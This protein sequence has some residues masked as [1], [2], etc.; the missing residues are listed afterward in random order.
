MEC[1]LSWLMAR[2]GLQFSAADASCR[3]LWAF[4]TAQ[5]CDQRARLTALL[6]TLGSA[7]A[8]ARILASWNGKPKLSNSLA[9][10]MLVRRRLVS[11]L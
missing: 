1:G 3:L 11:L 5:G 10:L 9:L 4:L 8:S 2:P 7:Y 6:T